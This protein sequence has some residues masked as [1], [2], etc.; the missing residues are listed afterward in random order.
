MSNRFYILETLG[1]GYQAGQEKTMTG[2]YFAFNPLFI[3]GFNLYQE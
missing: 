3:K 2:A 1:K